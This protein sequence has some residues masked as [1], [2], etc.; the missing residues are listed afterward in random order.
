M[1]SLSWLQQIAHLLD[2]RFR[3]PGTNIRFGFDPILALIP[4]IGDLPSPIF[5][6]ALIVQGLY[7]GVPRVIMLK[8]L[9]NAIVD[10]VI[11]AVPVAGAVGDMFFR[12][13]VRNMALLERHS[14][15]GVQPTRGDYAFVMLLSA[16]FGLVV[17]IPIVIG[18]TL[19]YAL[20]SALAERGLV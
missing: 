2:S 12:A 14:R 1:P 6:V 7:Q 9:L 3:I 16:L 20:M 18:L 8:M 4:G 17:L 10:A 15:P 19:A 5:A 13:N 11:G